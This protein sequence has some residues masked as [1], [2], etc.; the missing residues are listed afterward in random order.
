[1]PLGKFIR[2]NPFTN[3][4]YTQNEDF[5]YNPK[6]P[7]SEPSVRANI[8]SKPIGEKTR[9]IASLQIRVIL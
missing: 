3:K 2:I 7:D 9:S 8:K 1:M 5:L 4:H 6:N